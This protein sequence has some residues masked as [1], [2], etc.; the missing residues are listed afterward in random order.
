M[1][2]GWSMHVMTCHAQG[3]YSPG[4]HLHICQIF[5]SQA[6]LSHI[7]PCPHPAQVLLLP[8]PDPEVGVF[9]CFPQPFAPAHPLG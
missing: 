9:P 4:L 5:Q 7:S 2:W 3:V 1:V 8:G 6:Q